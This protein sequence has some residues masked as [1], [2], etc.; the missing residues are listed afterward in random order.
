MNDLLVF[1]TEKLEIKDDNIKYE[2]QKIY[3]FVKKLKTG[4]NI[5]LALVTKNIA[6]N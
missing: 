5:L 2:L 4:N 1:S 6:D 3:K